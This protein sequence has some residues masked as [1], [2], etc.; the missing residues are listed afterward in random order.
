[1]LNGSTLVCL[2]TTLFLARWTKWMLIRCDS[3][4]KI[5][6]AMTQIYSMDKHQNKK[7]NS[8]L[9]IHPRQIKSFRNGVCMRKLLKFP[10]LEWQTKEDVDENT[11]LFNGRNIP[12]HHCKW[13]QS[14]LS[15][16][17]VY[18]DVSIFDTIVWYGQWHWIR[19]TIGHRSNVFY[20]TSTHS[21][22]LGIH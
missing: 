8:F 22:S 13:H 21:V 9:G 4:L 6:H 11:R 20:A 7:R 5:L 12:L 10:L 19:M 17:M 14:R 18:N 15:S 3:V 16:R 1:M 2:S